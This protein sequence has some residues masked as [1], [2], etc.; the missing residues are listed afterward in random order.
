VELARKQL[1]FHEKFFDVF[2]S[3]KSQQLKISKDQQSVARRTNARALICWVLL[4]PFLNI[5]CPLRDLLQPNI[6]SHV[7]FTATHP[8]IRQLPEK[9]HMI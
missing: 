8:L 9:Y 1:E 4:I 6:L 3:I 7:C 5:T 2:L